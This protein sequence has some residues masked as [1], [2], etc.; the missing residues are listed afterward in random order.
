M[1][2]QGKK[3]LSN[4]E[5]SK[6]R[7][8]VKLTK[9]EQLYQIKDDKGQIIDFEQANGHQ[10][11]NHY[12]HNMTNYD[13]VLDSIRTEQGYVTGRQ[14]K[15]AVIGAAEQVLK[16]YR[17]EHAKVIQNSQR[18]NSFLKTLMQKA[19]VGTASAL[20]N[21]LDA[22][23]N[24]IKDIAKLENSQRSLQFW[25]DTYRVQREL[26]KKILIDEEVSEEVIKKVNAI[27][28]TRSVNKAVAIGSELFNLE[29]SEILKLIKSVVRY[30]LIWRF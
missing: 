30:R 25:N 29:K 27:Y 18:Q 8:Q 20:S 11:F 26:V 24:R 3:T 28:K 10:I 12:R 15:K 1:Y 2:S 4:N 16:L 14:E 5:D 7:E 19:G 6:I 13:Q 22:C 9:P 17:D 21:I 23:S